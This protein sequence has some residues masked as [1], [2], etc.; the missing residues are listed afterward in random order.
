MDYDVYSNQGNWLYIAGWGTDDRAAAGALTR[1]KPPNMMRMGLSALMG[2]GLKRT[3]RRSR[4][5]AQRAWRGARPRQSAA[6]R[7]TT[8]GGFCKRCYARGALRRARGA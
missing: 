4:N 6:G 7:T 5:A 1:S 3:E 2:H 8:P